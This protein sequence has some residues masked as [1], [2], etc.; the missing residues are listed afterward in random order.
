MTVPNDPNT[1]MILQQIFDQ[2][3]ALRND[4]ST[5]F[6]R[7]D[8]HEADIENLQKAVDALQEQNSGKLNRTYMLVAIGS[9]VLNALIT[10][11]GL[12]VF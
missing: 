11:H 5:N 12:K 1:A 4:I 10:L 8:L 3:S 7:K 9:T 2:I 6:V